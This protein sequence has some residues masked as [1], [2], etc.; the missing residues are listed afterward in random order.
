MCGATQQARVRD[1]DERHSNR[2]PLL[3]FFIQ[4]G[5]RRVCRSGKLRWN[6]EVNRRSEVTDS[7][8]IDKDV[9]ADNVLRLEAGRWVGSTETVPLPFHLAA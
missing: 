7:R 1:I 5:A 9:Q 3:A 2:G 6:G 4:V 8:A